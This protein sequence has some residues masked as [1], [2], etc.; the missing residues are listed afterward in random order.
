[1]RVVSLFCGIGGLDQGFID[2]GYDIVWANDFDRYA[3]QTYKANY[4][5][6]IVLGDINEIPLESIPSLITYHFHLLHVKH[7]MNY[8]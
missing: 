4:D 7:L 2:A 6:E 8:L 3:V 5:N 1:M